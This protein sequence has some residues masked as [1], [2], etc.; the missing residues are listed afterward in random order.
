MTTDVEGKWVW[1]TD[2]ANHPDGPHPNG[3]ENP[4]E[5]E[6]SGSVKLLRAPKPGRIPLLYEC[7]R[8]QGGIL[9]NSASAARC[10]MV[11]FA[12]VTNV[13]SKVKQCILIHCFTCGIL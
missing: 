5:Q 12:D 13:S 2:A 4:K 8:R 9:S 1:P 10:P 11:S 3:I 7:L 6:D